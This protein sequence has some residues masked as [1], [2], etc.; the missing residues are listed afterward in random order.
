MLQN[1]LLPEYQRTFHDT[2]LTKR[3]ICLSTFKMSLGKEKIEPTIYVSTLI[4]ASDS[5]PNIH[6]PVSQ[7]PNLSTYFRLCEIY[8][9]ID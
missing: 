1:I 2:P 9:L 6:M 5:C 7:K 8:I 3:F 4:G